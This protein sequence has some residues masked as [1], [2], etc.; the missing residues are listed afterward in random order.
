MPKLLN[1]SKMVSF[2]TVHDFFKHAMKKMKFI[3]VNGKSEKTDQEIH[4]IVF[5]KSFC[6][7]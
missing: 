5:R 4:R 2:F 1:A 7:C 6:L 3:K